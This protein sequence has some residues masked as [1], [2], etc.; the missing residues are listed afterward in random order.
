MPSVTC[1]ARPRV[2][3]AAIQATTCAFYAVK[4]DEFLGCG[5]RRSLAHPRQVAMALCRRLTDR[6]YPEIAKAFRRDHTT[7]LHAVDAVARRETDDK[8]LR[9]GMAEIAAVAARLT[10]RHRVSCVAHLTRCFDA[11]AAVGLFA[12]SFGDR[13]TET[14]PPPAPNREAALRDGWAI[15]IAETAKTNAHHEGKI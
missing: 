10:E 11:A 4:P 1:C 9:A 3:I 15:Q 7:V 12:V 6:S 5:R 8:A 2:T 13:L 14:V